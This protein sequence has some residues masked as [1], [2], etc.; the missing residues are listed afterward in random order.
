MSSVKRK[1]I[2]KGLGEEFQ[3]LKDLE[4]GLSN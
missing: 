1:L 4:K 3:A 2:V